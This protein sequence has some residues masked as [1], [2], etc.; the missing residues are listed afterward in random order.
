MKD[1]AYDVVIDVDKRYSGIV[2][3]IVN[4]EKQ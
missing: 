4:I 2:L 3:Y 1:Y